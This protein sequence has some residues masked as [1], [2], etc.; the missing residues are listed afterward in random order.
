MSPRVI[1]EILVNIAV[2][3]LSQYIGTRAPLFFK[4]V[5]FNPTLPVILVMS[6]FRTHVNIW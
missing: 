3:D 1:F 6:L 4:F 5:Y 2:H